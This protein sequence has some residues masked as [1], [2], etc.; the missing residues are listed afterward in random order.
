[1]I[2]SETP[3]HVSRTTSVMKPH[4]MHLHGPWQ[5]EWLSDAPFDQSRTRSGRVKIPD[6]WNTLF[7]DIAGKVLFRR[8]FHKPTNLEQH[9]HVYLI[10]VKL[11]GRVRISVNDVLLGAAQNPDETLD[12]EITDLLKPANELSLEIE[13]DSVSTASESDSKQFSLWESVAIEIRTDSAT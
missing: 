12:F 6:E 11:K 3:Q 5:Y 1:M 10:I 8:R 9:E 2:I 13:Y 4:R 7:G